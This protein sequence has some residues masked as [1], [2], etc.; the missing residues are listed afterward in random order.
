[1][2]VADFS[3]K[4]S[5]ILIENKELFDRVKNHLLTQ[6]QKALKNGS[7]AYRGDDGLKCAVGV[8]IKDEFYDQDFEG[9]NTGCDELRA[10][11]TKSGVDLNDGD[12][13]IML[14]KLQDCH[15]NTPVARW[16]ERLDQIEADFFE[17]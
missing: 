14:H 15:D 12:I 6:G 2:G 13:I 3:D 16:P 11:L 8:L 5:V 1:M 7:C 17:T 4:E 10:A 9:L